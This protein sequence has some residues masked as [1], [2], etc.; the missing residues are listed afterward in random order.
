MGKK[1][2]I[3]SP[4]LDESIAIDLRLYK[5]ISPSFKNLEKHAKECAQALCEKNEFYRSRSKS[6][7]A[8][9]LFLGTELTEGTS[10]NA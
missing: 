9:F 6:G 7:L 4:C 10:E 8:A 2:G 1:G 5:L 3:N